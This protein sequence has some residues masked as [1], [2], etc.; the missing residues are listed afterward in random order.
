MSN[1]QIDEKKLKN[2]K[3]SLFVKKK[4]GIEKKK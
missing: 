1:S 2:I 4:S 3:N